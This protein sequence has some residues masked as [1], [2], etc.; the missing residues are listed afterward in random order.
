M[1]IPWGHIFLA[2]AMQGLLGIVLYHCGVRLAF[3][4]AALLP[5]GYFWGRETAQMEVKLGTLPPDTISPWWKAWDMSLWNQGAVLDFVYP[6]VVCIAMAWL[7]G[8][9]GRRRARARKTLND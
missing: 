4:M 7:V 9:V 1:T 6:V 5:T 8:V 3:L 2:L